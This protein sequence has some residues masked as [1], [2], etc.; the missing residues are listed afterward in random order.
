MVFVYIKEAHA[1]VRDDE[2][3]IVDGWPI[4]LEVENAPHKTLGDRRRCATQFA[5]DS[6]W[7]PE[8]ERN[9]MGR[10]CR[11]AEGRK[12][13]MDTMDDAFEAAYGAWPDQCYCF[14]DGRLVFRGQLSEEGHRYEYSTTQLEQSGLLD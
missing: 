4:G 6:C 13:Y 11:Q 3:K 8:P 5:A 7:A 10:R 2:G 14:R 1:V 9:A 12:T